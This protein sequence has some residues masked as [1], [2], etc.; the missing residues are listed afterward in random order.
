MPTAGKL[1]VC[2][3]EAKNLKKMDVGGLSGNAELLAASG[4]HQ[5]AS[6]CHE[7]WSMHPQP[8]RT[9]PTLEFCCLPLQGSSGFPV[10]AF[11]KAPLYPIKVIFLMPFGHALWA[12]DERIREISSFK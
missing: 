7:P 4:W 3:L 2:I 10:P 8:E 11:S 1:T 5:R 6:H 12:M 9:L